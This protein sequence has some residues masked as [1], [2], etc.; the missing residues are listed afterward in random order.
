M[1]KNPIM[2]NITTFYFGKTQLRVLI[3]EQGYPL[4][5]G[6]DVVAA[7]GCTGSRE[8]IKR[9]VDTED[10]DRLPVNTTQSMTVVN[11]SGLFTLIYKSHSNRAKPFKHWITSEVLPFINK[12]GASALND[13]DVEEISNAMTPYQRLDY[14]SRSMDLMGQLGELSEQDKEMYRASIRA[15]TLEVQPQ[16]ES[17]PQSQQESTE[18]R[19]WSIGDAA[20]ELGYSLS[21][22]IA[23][24]AGKEA[25]SAYYQ[26]YGKHPVRENQVIAGSQSVRRLYQK[27]DVPMLQSI[28]QDVINNDNEALKDYGLRA[29]IE[30]LNEQN[31]QNG[32]H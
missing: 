25:A 27:T 14:L 28:I 17:Q 19:Y 24:R 6:K 26:H 4:F 16:H 5:V 9:K 3:D 21:R 1:Q 23:K 7:L 32:N 13:T 31:K 8:L 11:E 12:Y 20:Q 30:D 10:K 2:S 29:A 22:D 18:Q 15:L